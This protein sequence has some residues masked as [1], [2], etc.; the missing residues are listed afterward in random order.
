MRRALP[1]MP[2]HPESQQ[3]AHLTRTAQNSIETKTYDFVVHTTKNAERDHKRPQPEEMQRNPH[4][5]QLHGD[6]RPNTYRILHNRVLIPASNIERQL[7]I[8]KLNFN[9]QNCLQRI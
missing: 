9:F 6:L 7:P 2:W 4:A 3:P 1:R 8:W 5:Q